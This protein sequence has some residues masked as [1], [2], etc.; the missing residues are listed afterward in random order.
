MRGVIHAQLAWNLAL[1]STFLAL[2]HLYP[3]Y[4]RSSFVSCTNKKLSRL[5]KTKTKICSWNLGQNQ[6]SNHKT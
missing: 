1:N 2:S 6:S 5:L 3:F 4:L